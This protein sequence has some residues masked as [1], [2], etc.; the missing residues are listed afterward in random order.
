MFEYKLL[1][2]PAPSKKAKGRKTIPDRFTHALGEVL[3]EQA[4]DGWEYAGQETF[5]LIEKTGMMGKEKPIELRRLI[6]RRDLGGKEMS[7]DEKLDKLW[8]ERS[9]TM[10][11]PSPEPIPSPPPLNETITANGE[12]PT[13]IFSPISTETE[14]PDAPALGPAEKP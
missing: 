6:F 9:A 4:R 13:R 5:P 14:T 8:Q 2:V 1:P 7:L 12:E 11:Q 3:N 10:A